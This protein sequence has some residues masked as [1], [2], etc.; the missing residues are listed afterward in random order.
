MQCHR[1][2]IVIDDVWEKQSWEAIRLASV[3][4]NRD[5][6]IIITTRKLEVAAKAGEVYKLQPLPYDNSKTYS[7]QEYMV[8][9]EIVL[10]MSQIIY[11]IKF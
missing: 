2:F 3:D 9:K 1:Y 5:S 8:M 4:K 11:L 6:R 7:I 10:K